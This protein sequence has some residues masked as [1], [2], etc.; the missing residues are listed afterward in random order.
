[1]AVLAIDQGT[2]GTKAIVVDDDG[3]VLAIS[4]QPVYPRYLADGGVEHDPQVLLASVLDTGRDAV[5]Q[6]NCAIDAVS[7]ANQGETVLAWDPGTGETLS[8]AIVWQ[9][10]RA[11]S[12][13]DT[14]TAHREGIRA[15]TGLELDSY[16]SAPKMRWLRDQVGAGGVITTSDTW[17]V[18]ALT[19]EFV[20]DRTTAGRSLITDLR[21]TDWDRELLALF[22]LADE[23]LPTIVDNDAIIGTTAAF[24]PPAPV[25]GLVVDQQAAL[26]AQGCLQPGTA[27]CTFG[28]GAFL[29]ANVG[30]QPTLSTRGLAACVGWRLRSQTT[31][32]FDG[33]AYTA[34][35]AVRWLQNLG[36][37][38]QPADLD[39]LAVA[40]AGGVLFVPALAGLAAPWWRPDAR[41]SFVGM[42]LSTGRGELVTA[43]L[44]GLA[45]QT[46]E[47]IAA[48][49]ADI[50]QPLDR[51]RVDGGLTRSR[52]LMQAVADI[53]Q[54]PVDVYPS[55]HAT[56][57]GAAACARLSIDPTLS[58]TDAVPPWSPAAT[59]EPRW[60]SDRANDFRTRWHAA[61]TSTLPQK[62]MP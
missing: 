29:L 5:M 55:P 39:E 62:D 60:D 27:K 23:P 10:R 43:V 51:L 58:I 50:A 24:G 37:I 26:L 38:A 36:V 20:T 54:I 2:S 21:T 13:C 56:A 48:M 1:M 61:A 8:P 40:D 44:E 28:T 19:G 3:A 18:H 9:D 47:V 22:G 59:Y 35:S 14:L 42:G 53:G 12:V 4:E 25:A 52:R 30:Q 17:L 45:A 41:A 7:L 46:V 57:L 32:C 6:A 15:R 31:Y 11:E 33:Q 34:G 16:F 49:Q